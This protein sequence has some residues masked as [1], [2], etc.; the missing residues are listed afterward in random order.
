MN[1][2]WRDFFITSA[3][4]AA[5]L[6]GLIFVSLSVNIAHILKW[7]HLPDRAVATL[8]ALMLILTVSLADLM[9]QGGTALGVEVLFFTGFV[10]WL[11]LRSGLT[12]IR[13]GEANGRPPWESRFE[14]AAG[15]AQA[16]PFL[17]G[18]VLLLIGG[19]GA[20]FW[21]A[22]GTLTVFVFSAVNAW[23]LLVEILR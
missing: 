15:Q 14:L 4:A 16:L 21:L 5:A 1:A 3:G 20:R 19:P 9:P 10:W 23:V 11:Q 18:A 6:A 12:A 2:D 7:S 22:G 17:V 8:G 13:S